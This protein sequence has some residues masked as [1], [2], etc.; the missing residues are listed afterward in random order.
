M[1][2][3]AFRLGFLRLT[4][5]LRNTT[6]RQGAV[7]SNRYLEKNSGPITTESRE[8]NMQVTGKSPYAPN[9]TDYKSGGGTRS[10]ATGQEQRHV[11]GRSLQIWCTRCRHTCCS[12]RPL[13]ARV[14]GSRDAAAGA[15]PECCSDAARD[16]GG[17]TASETGD[18]STDP[19]LG[20]SSKPVASRG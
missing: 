20:E 1:G 9:P 7:M 11:P 5:G 17:L 16:R 19:N 15:D 13:G 2:P 12:S 3:S 18:T 8:T 10:D 6:R 14:R 4:F